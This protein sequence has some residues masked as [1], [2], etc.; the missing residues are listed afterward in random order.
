M[1]KIYVYLHFKLSHAWIST[2]WWMSVRF[3]FT[4]FCYNRLKSNVYW[5]LVANRC[6]SGGH[7]CCF[8]TQLACFDY[9]FCVCTVFFIPTTWKNFSQRPYNHELATLPVARLLSANF[10]VNFMRFFVDLTAV[11]MM[12]VVATVMPMAA[13]V[14][15]NHWSDLT[16]CFVTFF[17]LL[18]AT[19]ALSNR[20]RFGIDMHSTTQQFVIYLRMYF[21]RSQA[22]IHWV[23]ICMYAAELYIPFCRDCSQG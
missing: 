18:R 22:A 15:P 9:C 14:I 2:K 21:V 20:A 16:I 7:C 19:V 10:S 1:S 11:W 4:P 5:L 6:L 12:V 17:P 23:G 13:S 3:F 8:C